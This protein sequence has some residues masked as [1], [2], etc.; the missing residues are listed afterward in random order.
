MSAHEPGERY[1]IQQLYKGM[2]DNNCI[3]G[4]II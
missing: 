2:A 1:I 3:N 4:F